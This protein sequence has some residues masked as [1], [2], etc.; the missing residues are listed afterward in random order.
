MLKPDGHH[1]TVS[2]GKPE[3]RVYH[4]ERPYLSWKLREFVLYE[5]GAETEEENEEKCTYIYVCQKKNDANEV[6]DEFFYK[7]YAKLMVDNET[8]K[9]L[10]KEYGNEM[11]ESDSD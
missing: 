11:N 10:E 9:L 4:F 8:E 5:P 7:E 1:V 2:Y 6:S 3:S